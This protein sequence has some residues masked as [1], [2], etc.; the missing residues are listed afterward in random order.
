MD[1]L[2][3]CPLLESVTQM[4]DKAESG[5]E[6]GLGHL[7]ALRFPH[8]RELKLKMGYATHFSIL[9]ERNT[10]FFSLRLCIFTSSSSPLLVPTL[11]VLSPVLSL[12]FVFLFECTVS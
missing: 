3:Q 12:R 5:E 1:A 2:S 4:S 8:L 6:V 9:S 7:K 10:L 11:L